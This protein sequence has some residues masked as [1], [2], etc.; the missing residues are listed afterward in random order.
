MKNSAN[1]AV[2]AAAAMAWT[3]RAG[4][5]TTFFNR[6]AFQDA[7]PL[8]A[9]E[10]FTGSTHFPI[11]TGVLNSETNL[12][13]IGLFP[14]MIEPGVTYST[15]IGESFFFNIDSGGGYPDGGFLDGFET[16]REVTMV[17]HMNDPGVARTIYGFG[18][19]IGSLG[20]TDFDVKVK[21]ADG[22]EQAFN[23]PYPESTEFFGFLSDAQDIA[24]VVVGCNNGF[25][26]FDFD[27]FTYDTVRTG[28]CEPDLD[29]NG[30]LDLF[31]FLAFTNLFNASDLG[32]D[33]DPDGVLDLFD[34]LAFTNAFNA[35]C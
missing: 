26:G 17:F 27:N 13:E 31:D 5:I 8:Q 28:G 7:A 21:F 19:E 22:S 25:F 34:F 6:S 3:A 10:D 1:Y 12:P 18:F 35:G 24:S 11:S 32:A 15:P 4:T 33:F 2:L 23:Y 20:A 30:V 16:D 9:V 14:G 29:D